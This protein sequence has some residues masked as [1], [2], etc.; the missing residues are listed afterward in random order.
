MKLATLRTEQGLRPAMRQAD[1]WHLID[2]ADVI[3]VL[4]ISPDRIKLAAAAPIEASKAEFAPPIP[5]PG[6][7]LCAGMNYR[8]HAEELGLPVP[9]YPNLFA[10]FQESLIG[11]YDPMSIPLESTSC[12]YEVELVIVIGREVRRANEQAA[13]EAIGGFCVG[14]DGSVRDWQLR[15]R[16]AMQGKAWEGMSSFGPCVTTRD[17]IGD[18]SGLGIRCHVNGELRQESNTADM[19]FSCPWLVSYISTFTTLKPGDIIFT[20]TPSGVG[21]TR[22]PPL[23]L[24]RGDVVRCEIDRLGAIENRFGLADAR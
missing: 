13:K 20:G 21:F 9:P 19:V 16:E 12:D 7:I 23:Y 1:A 14:N 18:G 15:T 2:A 8:S 17:E 11:P 10:K 22:K 3:S 6:K 24:R 4:G 5:K